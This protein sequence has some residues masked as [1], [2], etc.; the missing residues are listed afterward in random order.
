[1]RKQLSSSMT[2]FWKF[3]FSAFWITVF[4]LGVSVLL[5]S[6]H[7]EGLFLLLIFIPA[8]IF[9]YFTTIQV[10]RISI[11]SEYLYIDNFKKSVKTPLSNIK[12][13]NDI[14]IFSPRTI[15]VYFKEPTEF[16]NKVSFIAYTKMMLFFG[17]HPAAKK[18]RNRINS[19]N[20]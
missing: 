1:M 11:D 9:I 10:K 20:G 4:G 3:I 5:F 12:K 6:S 14:V 8:I 7:S 13:I 16:G 19:K 18:I 2:F 17:D 15:I